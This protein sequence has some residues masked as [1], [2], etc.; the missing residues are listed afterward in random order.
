MTALPHPLRGL[1]LDMDGVLVDS[2]EVHFEAWQQLFAE[3]GIHLEPERFEDE[4]VGLSREAVLR[5][6]LGERSDRET[7]MR[8][9]AELVYELLATGGCEPLPGVVDF[10][11]EADARKLPIAVATASL[12]PYPF[13]ASAGLSERLPVV[14]HR[15]NVARGKPAPDVYLAAAEALGL[16]P[17][18]CIAVEDSPSGIQAAVAAGCFT[19]A[20]TTSYEPSRLTHADVVLPTLDTLW[21]LLDADRPIGPG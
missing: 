20:V 5:R 11:D 17:S 14:R 8:R 10:L 13:L 7:L 9:K 21:A 18:S 15:G 16:T 4:V 1:L 2:Q 12:M 3:Q 6:I 19:A